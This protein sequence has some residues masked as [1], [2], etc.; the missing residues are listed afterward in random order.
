MPSTS[1]LGSDRSII[2]LIP[3]IATLVS[4]A[5]VW[6]FLGK[7]A[8]FLWTNLAFAIFAGFAA[9]AWWRTRSLG[10]LASFLYLLACTFMLAVKTGIIPGD[11]EIAPAFAVLLMASIISLVFVLLTRQAKWRGRDILE[12]A[13][14]PVEDVAEGFSARPLPVGKVQFTRDEILDFAKFARRKLIA[15]TYEEESRVAFENDG[16]V[17]V[18][19]S[20]GD[21]LQYVDDLD[22]DQL[23]RSLADVFIDFLDLHIKDQDNRIVARMDAMN[24]GY[25]S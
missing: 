18:N 14:R 15:M 9:V 12:L 25:F 24:I 1:K 22:F 16:S 5:L 20:R 11:R 8:A 10:Y 3:A 23:C 7:N 13:A 4:F 17:T 2:G 6:M 19:I 21:Y